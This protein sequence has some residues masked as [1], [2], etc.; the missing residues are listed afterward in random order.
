[1]CDA[2]SFAGGLHA[3]L[4]HRQLP[5]ICLNPGVGGGT[6]ETRPAAEGAWCSLVRSVCDLTTWASIVPITEYRS[7]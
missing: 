2:M 5:S 4:E 1:M 3:T 6:L 7:V